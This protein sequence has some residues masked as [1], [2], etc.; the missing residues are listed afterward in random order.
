M[1]VDPKFVESLLEALAGWAAMKDEARARVVVEPRILDPLYHGAALLPQAA[2]FV[3][4]TRWRDG[5]D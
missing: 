3:D 1:A 5:A 2:A 4:P